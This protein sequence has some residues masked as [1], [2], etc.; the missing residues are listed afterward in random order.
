MGAGHDIM[1]SLFRQLRLLSSQFVA[2][3]ETGFVWS[4]RNAWTLPFVSVFTKT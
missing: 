2:F 1:V 4:R 3:R